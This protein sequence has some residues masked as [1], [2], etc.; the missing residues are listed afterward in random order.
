M[1][2]VALAFLAAAI[3][4][5]ALAADGPDPAKVE[6][7]K[8]EKRVC[9]SVPSSVSRMGNVIC[10]TPTEWAKGGDVD[11]LSSQVRSERPHP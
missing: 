6:K 11:E 2:Y 9:K 4:G 10:K 5:S 1:R 8:K 3:S 7:P